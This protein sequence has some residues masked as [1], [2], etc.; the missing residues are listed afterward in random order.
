METITFTISLPVAF[1]LAILVEIVLYNEDS[2]KYIKESVDAEAFLML[3]I[4]VILRLVGINFSTAQ[5]FMLA[6]VEFV[7]AFTTFCVMSYVVKRKTI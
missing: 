4:H 6:G 5:I 3:G 7:A 2:D 1:F